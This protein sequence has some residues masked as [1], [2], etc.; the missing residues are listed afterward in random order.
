MENGDLRSYLRQHRRPSSTSLLLSWLREMIYTVIRVH[1]RR[2][3]I[4]DIRTPNF[5]LAADLAIKLCDFA[6]SSIL[7]LDT[8]MHA[9]DYNGYSIYTDI[10]QL[11]AVIYEIVAGQQCAFDLFRISQPKPPG[12]SGKIFPLHRTSGLARPSINVGGKMRFAT[13][14]ISCMR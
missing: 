14:M 8:D 12:Q 9:A 6:E 7:P 13:G 4:A 1:E 5:L 11:G 2:V 10:G 3:I